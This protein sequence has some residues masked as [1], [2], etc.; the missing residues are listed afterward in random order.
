MEPNWTRRLAKLVI[1]WGT[2]AKN[3]YFFR[4]YCLFIFPVY[5]TWRASNAEKQ[6]RRIISGITNQNNTG[7]F[8]VRNLPKNNQ[9]LSVIIEEIVAILDDSSNIS[10]ELEFSSRCTQTHIPGTRMYTHGYHDALSLI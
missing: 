9:L 6:H 3:S 10:G 7:N 4:N 1:I 5:N 8:F 2:E